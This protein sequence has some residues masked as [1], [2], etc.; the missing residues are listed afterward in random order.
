[1]KSVFDVK[2]QNSDIKQYYMLMQQAFRK[3]LHF[4]WK[5]KK[6]CSAIHIHRESQS[7]YYFGVWMG[8]EYN[9]I[10]LSNKWN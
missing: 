6:M 5:Q 4:I 9:G 10:L 3:Y 1:M 8:I 2:T 7:H